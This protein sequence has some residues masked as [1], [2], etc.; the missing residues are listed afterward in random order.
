MPCYIPI[1]FAALRQDGRKNETWTITLFLHYPQFLQKLNSTNSEK[2]TDFSQTSVLTTSACGN[3][4]ATWILKL[5]L[6]AYKMVNNK[7]DSLTFPDFEKME[8]G[9]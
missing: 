2:F 3:N 6:L 8:L 4:F 1:Y 9:T 7:K 5:I